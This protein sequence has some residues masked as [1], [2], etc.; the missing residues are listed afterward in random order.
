M[1]LKIKTREGNFDL[2]EDGNM[3]IFISHY[4]GA[5]DRVVTRIDLK[6]GDIYLTTDHSEKHEMTKLCR[7]LFLKKESFV[8]PTQIIEFNWV[9]ENE[10][11]TLIQQGNGTWIIL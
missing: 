9:K 5:S 6:N 7:D 3:D 8:D 2:L 11:S 4:D 1:I 10:P